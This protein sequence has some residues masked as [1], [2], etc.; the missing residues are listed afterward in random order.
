MRRA[1]IKGLPGNRRPRPEHQMPTAGDLVHRPFTRPLP[2]QRWVTDITE[3]PTR[4]GK[5]YC[6][7]VL[8][9]CTRRVA[10]WSIDASQTAALVTSALDMAIRNRAATPGAVI[11]SDHGVHITSWARACG[12]LPSM[13]SIGDCY[14]NAMIESFWGRAQAKLP[15]RQHWRTRIELANA[16]FDYLEI[17][18][19]RRRR[20]S[21]SACSH[22]PNTNATSA[23]PNPQHD[24]NPATRHRETRGTSES[25]DSSGRFSLALSQRLSLVPRRDCRKRMNMLACA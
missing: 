25:P 21:A 20:Q 24:H 22:P 2:D 1:A 12:L 4:E 14:D 10:G 3:H 7:V 18:H 15:N 17:F 13:G 19:N 8:A 6:A 5:L 23:Q 9:A 11:H 16:L